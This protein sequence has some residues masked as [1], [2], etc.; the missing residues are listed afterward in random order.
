M[1]DY[2]TEL[3]GPNAFK[4]TD[5]EDDEV[6]KDGQHIRVPL[7]MMDHAPPPYIRDHNNTSLTRQLADGA[8][9]VYIAGRRRLRSAALDAVRKTDAAAQAK[10]LEQA[11]RTGQENQAQRD[12]CS[13]DNREHAY[14]EYC[15]TLTEAWRK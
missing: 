1:R 12:Q 7:Y 11:W 15:R 6:L 13:P 5:E 14:S 8:E 2:F 3:Y 10:R 9:E 4:D